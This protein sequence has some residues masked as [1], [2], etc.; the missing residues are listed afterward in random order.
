MSLAPDLNQISASLD[1]LT[2]W[3]EK[4]AFSLW[5]WWRKQVCG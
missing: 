2:L 5:N 4:D 1:C 3:E